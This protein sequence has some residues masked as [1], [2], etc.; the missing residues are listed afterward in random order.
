MTQT[1]DHADNVVLLR[2]QPRIY[3]RPEHSISRKFVSDS[4]LK[5][6]YRLD[7]AGFQAYLV[8]GSVRDLLLGR[9]PKDFDIATNALPEQVR[10]LFRNC[11]LIGRRFRLA[12]VQFGR[13][14][15][16]VATFRAQHDGDIEGA[17]MTDQGR[18]LRDNV[19]GTLEEDVW[20][21]DFTVNA[22]Y[23]NIADF[24]IVDYVGGVEDLRAGRLRLIGDP[25]KRYREDPVRML[26]AARFATKLG[27]MLD[28]ATLESIP[29]LR[30]LLEDIAPARLFDEMLKMFQGGVGHQTFEVLRHHGLFHCLFPMTDDQLDSPEGEFAQRLIAAAL[31]STDLRVAENKPITPAFLLAALLWHVVE[32]EAEKLIANGVTAFD[33]MT[34]AADAVI[35]KQIARIAM[36]RRFSNVTREIWALQARLEKPTPKRAQRALEHPRF[37]AAYDFLLLRAE[38]GDPVQEEATFWT[39]YLAADED[40]RP[41]LL[42]QMSAQPD[43]AVRPGGA[44]RRRRRRRRPAAD[45]TE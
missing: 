36:P 45:A 40:A 28:S 31:R 35:S 22:L 30:H 32:E 43:G 20:R 1:A 24:S 33:A 39:E 25:D 17:A 38:A 27:F 10:E 26:R 14:I 15:I 16:E 23:Y 5:V 4:A 37:R 44:K 12:H 6:L 18:I 29:R 7:K 3:A 42:Q 34:L 9:E 2:P 21:R 41:R 11:R 19:Y 13:E 8:G